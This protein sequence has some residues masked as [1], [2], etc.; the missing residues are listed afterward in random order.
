MNSINSVILT[1]N[2]YNF[3]LTILNANSGD[4]SFCDDINYNK[5]SKSFKILVDGI[6]KQAVGIKDSPKIKDLLYRMITDPTNMSHQLIEN[7]K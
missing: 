7:S 2:T 4:Y 3:G 1:D 6:L 5:K